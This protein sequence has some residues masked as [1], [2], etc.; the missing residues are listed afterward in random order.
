MRQG[1]RTYIILTPHTLQLSDVQL[2]LLAGGQRCAA[3]DKERCDSAESA[4][5]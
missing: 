4:Q 1:G 2:S 5:F 3:D